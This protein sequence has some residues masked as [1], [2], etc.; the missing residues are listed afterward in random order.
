MKFKPR[1]IQINSKGEIYVTG[2][3]DLKNNTIISVFNRQ[4]ESL[5]NFGQVEEVKYHDELIKKVFNK[6]VY[7]HI[8][9]K[10]NIYLAEVE[11]VDVLVM[12]KIVTVRQVEGPVLA[13]VRVAV[14]QVVEGSIL[15][16]GGKVL[17]L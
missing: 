11:V 5:R 13:I 6:K 2:N 9:Q 1:S 16:R 10:D 3:V 8:D 17:F 14:Q 4:G 7:L 15:S 12:E